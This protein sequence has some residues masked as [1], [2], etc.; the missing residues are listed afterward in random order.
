VT[1][2]HAFGRIPGPTL[3]I[4]EELLLVDPETL[5]LAPV[6]QSV[7][8][9]VTVPAGEAAHEAYAAEVE[10]RSPVSASAAEASTALAAVRDAV[11]QAGATLVGAG[12]HPAG[13]HGDAELVADDRYEVVADSMRGLIRRTPECALHVHVGVPD[14]ESAIQAYNGLRVWL[15]LL[16]GLSANSPFWFGEDSGLASAR[17]FLVRPYPGRGVPRALRDYEDYCD[18]VEETTGAAG[19]SDYTFLWWDVRPHPRHGTVEVREMDAQSSLEDVAALAA[20]VHALAVS[21]VE[22]PTSP[23]PSAEAIG[24]SAFHAA[25]DGVDAT[26]WHEGTRRPLAEVARETVERVRST[27]RSLNAED[28]LDGIERILGSGGGAGRQ[29]AAFARGGMRGLL[30]MLVE[31]TAA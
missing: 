23:V 30:E 27:A 5:A 17:A 6:A 2:E 25:R 11:R 28:P 12:V 31:Q 20:L 21:E 15:P 16:A 29:R 10:L 1:V 3:G 13:A 18:L 14:P 22:Q 19:A 24:W 7:L 4:E 9:N 8:A 26:I